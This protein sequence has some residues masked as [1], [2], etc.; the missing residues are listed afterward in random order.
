MANTL[1]DIPE[2]CLKK[3][4]NYIDSNNSVEM[5]ST[6]MWGEHSFK[7]E[8]IISSNNLHSI[9]SVHPVEETPF[10]ESVENKL[11]TEN[12]TSDV[13][14]KL[15][16]VESV[17][18]YSITDEDTSQ[19]SFFPIKYHI[20]ESYYQKQKDV[21]WTAQEID[22]L[23]DR[24]DWEHMDEGTKTLVKFILFFFAQTDGILCVNLTHFKKETSMY[25]EAG[26]FYA[27]QEFMEVTHNET[28]SM[29]IEA[30]IRDPVEKHQAFNAIK[31]YP[32]IGNIANWMFEWMDNSIPLAERVIAFACIEGILFSSAFAAI[33]W[34]KRK[35]IL[36][37]LCQ[38]NFYIAR[39]ENLHTEF[40]V[41]LYHVMTE[42]DKKFE[43]VSEKRVHE[44]ISS[45]VKIAEDF[46]RDALK[47]ELI[48]MNADDMISYVKCT[49]NRLSESLGYKKIY[50]VENPFD[51]MLVIGLPNK[52]NFFESK[53]TE[54]A[55][56]CASEF[57]FDLE[58]DF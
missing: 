37:G 17:E 45:S 53:P 6:S 26:Y 35:N 8:N 11:F 7:D 36:H 56:Q 22:Y 43:S 18:K 57:N 48:G 4:E 14:N 42:I 32:S 38:A 52:S 39:D 29:L 2:D 16:S 25:K 24:N 30:L 1:V 41:A 44:I 5:L 20:L 12:S 21:F 47:V 46:T 13:E 33:Y 49:A 51:W 10:V 40:A 34:I 23:S 55:R 50:E 54:Y 28:Y 3:E 58:M 15:L 9:K 27:A 31:Y 19:Y